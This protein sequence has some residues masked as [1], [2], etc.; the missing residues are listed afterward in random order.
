MSGRDQEKSSSDNLVAVANGVSGNI[1]VT[2]QPSQA[3]SK[4][5]ESLFSVNHVSVNKMK[6]D[7]IERTGKALGVNADD[8]GSRDDFVDAMQK[9]VGK[10][11]MEGGAMALMGLEKELG[12]DK[13]GLSIED[14]INSAKDPDRNDKVTKALEKEAGITS[15]KLEE[16]DASMPLSLQPNEIG[17]YG[18]AGL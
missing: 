7:L 16:Q 15:E 13:L 3:Q 14:V 9:A 8:F 12:L 18:P 4:I 6:L 1:G 10:L 17:L 2:K 5:S 11:K